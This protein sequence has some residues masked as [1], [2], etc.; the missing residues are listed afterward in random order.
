MPSLNDKVEKAM[1]S[2]N[3]KKPFHIVKELINLK[4]TLKRPIGYKPKD[5]ALEEVMVKQVKEVEQKLKTMSKEKQEQNRAWL[6]EL[7]AI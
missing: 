5:P 2:L 4:K 1:P 7:D 3:D 6:K